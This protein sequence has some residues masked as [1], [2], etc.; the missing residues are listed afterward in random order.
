MINIQLLSQYQSIQKEL[1][2]LADRIE[3]IY[4][5]AMFPSSSQITGMPRSPG[6]ST[7]GLLKIFLQIDELAEFYKEKQAELNKLCRQ[8]EKE[9]EELPSL[10]R[11]IIRFRYIDGMKWSEISK[12]TGYS[13][14]QLWRLHDK[15]TKDD[16]P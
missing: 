9:I 11:R 5:H 13:R 1:S 3:Q 15:I 10:E 4:S 14:A 16:A 7:G 6:Y 12:L 2:E 8:I